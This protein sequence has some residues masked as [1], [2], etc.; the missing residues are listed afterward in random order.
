MEV[1]GRDIILELTTSAASMV[2]W[3]IYL[4]HY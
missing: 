3:H 2:F 4:L 1:S